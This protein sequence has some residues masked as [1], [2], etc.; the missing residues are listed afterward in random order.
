MAQG[1]WQFQYQLTRSVA[2]E[3]RSLIS[4]AGCHAVVGGGCWCAGVLC[5]TLTVALSV[6]YP[7]WKTLDMQHTRLSQQREAAPAAVAQ[8]APFERR[9]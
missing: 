8:S 3:T 2:R 4:G 7:G 5:L 6:G 9:G 1:R